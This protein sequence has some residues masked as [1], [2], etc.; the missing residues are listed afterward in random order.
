MSVRGVGGARVPAQVIDGKARAEQKRRELEREIQELAPR[1]GRP[2]GLAV[3][4]VGEHPASTVYVRNKRRMCEALGIYAPA[5]DLPG[6]A[7]E[8]EL[9]ALIADLNGRQEVDGILVQSPLPPHIRT[10]GVLEAVAP[11]KDVDGFHPFN[12]GRLFAGHPT[13]VPCT[14]A[15]VLELVRGTG[16]ELSGARAVVVGRSNLVGKPTALLLLHE[17]ATVT[18]CHSRTRDLAG[19]CRE[20]DILVVAIGRREFVRGDWIKPGAVV[21]DVG[22][23]READR[24]LGDVEYAAARERAG[25]ITPVPGGVG[26]MT[27][28][29]LMANTVQAARSRLEGRTS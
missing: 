28:A 13:F 18:L 5:F 21:I 26:P 4:Q 20:A 23:N 15:G 8:A 12:L 14:A 10:E 29:W 9:L 24:L 11:D 22:I 25:F 6:S 27:V 19:I 17:H 16:V 1:L 7:T 2:P 3:I